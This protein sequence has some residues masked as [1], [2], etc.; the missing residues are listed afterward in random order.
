MDQFHP[1]FVIKVEIRT[2][3]VTKKKG[4]FFFLMFATCVKDWLK[5]M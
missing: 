1:K 5:L 4:F 3:F 2:W